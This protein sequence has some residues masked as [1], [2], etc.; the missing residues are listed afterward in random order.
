MQGDTYRLLAEGNRIRNQVVLAPRGLIKDRNGE[1]LAQN[2]ASYNLFVTPFDLPKEGL[3][4]EVKDLAATLSIAEEDIWEKLKKIDRN[5]FQPSVV[6]QDLTQA[7]SILFETKKNQFIGFAVQNIPIRQYFNPLA[8]SHLLGYAGIISSAEL[9]QHKTLDYQ[10]ADYIGKYG[11]ELSYEKFFRGVNGQN[12][13]EVDAKGNPVKVLG[14]IQ[15]EPGN[16][17]ELNIDKGLQ[18]ELYKGFEKFSSQTKGAAV[19]LNPKTG[20]VLALVSVPGFDNNL[21]AHGIKQADYQNLLNDKNLPLFTVIL[22]SW[23]IAFFEYCLQV[24]ANRIGHETFS[25][26]QL[27]TLQEAITFV[28]FIGFSLLYLQERPTTYDLAAFGLIFA[29]VAISILQPR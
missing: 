5:S 10:P 27:K 4:N 21:F 1:L 18:E 11:I 8:F 13:I 23:G 9:E 16:V 19:A 24:P 29:G 6:A 28:V 25:A 26:A 15:P 20:E 2:I 17:V 12:Q 14:Q 7:Q 3:E 22:A